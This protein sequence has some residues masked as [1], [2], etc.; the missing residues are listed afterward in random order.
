MG[1]VIPAGAPTGQTV[2]FQ[3][4]SMEN[5]QVANGVGLENYNLAHWA[6]YVISASEQTGSG[7]Y[8]A[9]IPGYLPNGYYV[10]NAYVAINPGSPAAGD[11]PTD[12]LRFG[13]K[14]GNIVD[15][16][17]SVDIGSINGST[18]AVENLSLSAEEYVIGEAVA[19]TLSTSQMTTNLTADVSNVYARRVMVFTSGDLAG[20]AVLITA[21]NPTGAKLTFIGY[22]NQTLPSAPSV[23]DAFLIL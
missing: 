12:L 16:I 1:G 6:N 9:S 11:T 10:A 2:Y 7:R 3:I 20:F 17:S 5:G 21:F 14:D 4:M 8:V 23:G 19:G 22:N 13:W 18:V 15:I